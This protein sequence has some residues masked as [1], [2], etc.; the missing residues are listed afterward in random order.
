MKTGYCITTR[1]FTL[2]C[3]H[4]EWFHITQELYNQV[5]DF[6][7]RLLLDHPNLHTLNNQQT[8][9]ELEILSIPG[10]DHAPVP[11]PL[12]ISFGESGNKI[13]L[14]FRR[15]AIN[16][17]NAMVKS[18]LNREGFTNQA[19]HIEASVVYYKGMYRDLTEDHIFLKVYDGT[20]WQWMNCRL[21][22][23]QLND[24]MEILSPT[25]VISGKDIRLH[26]PVKEEVTDARTSKERMNAGEN[27][28][29][30]QFTNSDAF[31]VACVMD[32][33]GKQL[34][35]KFLKGGKE[36][37]HHCA[38][39]LNQIQKSE[40]ARRKPDAEGNYQRE[41]PEKEKTN[42]KY[43]LHLKNL[44]DH[45]AHQVSSQIIAFCLEKGAKTIVVADS[46]SPNSAAVM[47][48]AGNWS[49]LHLSTRIREY[50]SYKAWKAGLVVL[51]VI[52]DKKVSVCSVCGAEISKNG[53]LYECVNGHKG[54]RYLNLARNVGRMCLE[55]FR[56]KSR[57]GRG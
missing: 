25:V 11:H 28:C 49:P 40:D 38:R 57:A 22:G 29:S 31:A 4:P 39:L 30:I 51:E 15:A 23:N 24:Q 32:G 52:P 53:E 19:S 9:R 36:Y 54:N 18:Y 20:R 50:V 2:R 35:V 7:Y 34:A 27:I 41:N 45:Y 33:E 37:S 47:K 3:K 55:D 46:E 13:P 5:V 14:Y 42:Q 6:Y 44:S 8:L 1:R 16:T 26:V 56:R 43:W 12:A 48:S 21:S 10:R 17:A